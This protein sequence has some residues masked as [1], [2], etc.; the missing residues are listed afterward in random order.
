MS[1]LISTGTKAKKLFK[2]AAKVTGVVITQF[3]AN[4]RY[5]MAFFDHACRFF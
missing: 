1:I 4:L 2:A 3:K 5:L